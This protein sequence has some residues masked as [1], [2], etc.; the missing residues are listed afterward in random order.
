MMGATGD[1][2][3]WKKASPADKRECCLRAL[4]VLAGL[5]TAEGDGVALLYG[6]AWDC[7]LQS[8]RLS[9]EI[10]LDWFTMNGFGV[11]KIN[12]GKLPDDQPFI[13]RAMNDRPSGSGSRAAASHVRGFL[14]R[15]PHC[16]I[17][18]GRSFKV[19]GCGSHATCTAAGCERRNGHVQVRTL[20]R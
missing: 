16:K 14:Q 18:V 20:I 9:G 3:K 11:D 10:D 15:R 5:A 13:G 2:S 1:K 8:G 6:D 4:K 7:I 19:A 12:I 17:M